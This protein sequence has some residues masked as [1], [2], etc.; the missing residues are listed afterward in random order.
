M[1][2]A[3]AAA[4]TVADTLSGI[5]VVIEE[6][7]GLGTLMVMV[8]ILVCLNTWQVQVSSSPVSIWQH[9]PWSV[10]ESVKR[11]VAGDKY[12]QSNVLI[13]FGV[14]LGQLS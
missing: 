4:S 1:P 11:W 14:S 6:A 12:R 5:A 8:L 9:I 3:L 10:C 13:N 2:V 7:V